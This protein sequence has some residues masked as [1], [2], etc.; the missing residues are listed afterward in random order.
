[1]I[2]TNDLTRF[3]KGQVTQLVL[4]PIMSITKGIKLTSCD[5]S[6]LLVSGACAVSAC[7]TY[8]YAK[9]VMQEIDGRRLKV[10]LNGDF[11]LATDHLEEGFGHATGMELDTNVCPAV[12]METINSS[13]GV[14]VL[15]HSP[16]EVKQHRR[17]KENHGM[18]YMNCI[19]SECKNKFLSP[20]RTTANIKAVTRFANNLMVK[21][22]LRATHIRKFLP[23]C[24][25]M[26]FVPTDEELEG[27]TMLNS[28]PSTSRKVEYLVERSMSSILPSKQ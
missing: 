18:K 26:T 14:A 27:L 8:T 6:A 1:M 3:I 15:D 13:R 28:F 2:T 24:V 4:K 9:W 7:A 19:I 17:V 10:L 23:M 11:G 20:E 12:K 16:V 22:G 25:N 5:R 21:H